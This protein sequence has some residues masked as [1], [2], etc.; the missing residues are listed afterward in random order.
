MTQLSIKVYLVFE[1]TRLEAH[2]SQCAPTFFTLHHKWCKVSDFKIF[3]HNNKNHNL[4][5]AR[6]CSSPADPG[7]RQKMHLNVLMFKSV[8]LPWLLGW[9][10]FNVSIF[11]SVPLPW[12]EAFK[13]LNQQLSG[14]MMWL[15]DT[16]TD[17]AFYSLRLN[18]Y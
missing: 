14:N 12:L 4:A 2:S 9:R 17:T 13:C 11:N 6:S 10:H 5:F 7:L 3:K 8:P 18:K 1:F 15:T 16:H